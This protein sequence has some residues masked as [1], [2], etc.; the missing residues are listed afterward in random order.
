[1]EL[2]KGIKNSIIIDDSYNSSPLA[3]TA[4]LDFLK[5]FEGRRKIAV[6]GDMLELGILER[7]AHIE[8]GKEAMEKSDIFVAVGE[9]MKIAFDVVQKLWGPERVYWAKDNQQTADLAEFL[10]RE[11]DVV[12]VKGSRKMEMEKI[13]EKIEIR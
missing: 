6:L 12:L 13:V 11:D 1:M 4:A 8:A 7:D 3:V 5:E 10:I 2:K 9:R